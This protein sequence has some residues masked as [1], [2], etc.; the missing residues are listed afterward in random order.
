MIVSFL[1]PLQACGL[2]VLRKRDSMLD[3]FVK[4][5]K[6]Y[7]ISFLQKTAVWWP[8]AANQNK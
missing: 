3:I 8:I 5:V 4:F 2:K 7:R 1:V 6:F